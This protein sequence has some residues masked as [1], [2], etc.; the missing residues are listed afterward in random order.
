MNMILYY[1][2]YYYHSKS[3]YPDRV[4]VGVVQQNNDG[5]IDCLYDY[6]NLMKK[7]KG[8]HPET[9]TSDKPEQILK[10]CPHHKQVR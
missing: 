1:Y 2:Y 3:E 8:I 9:T 5:D 7:E 10:N 6:C 4:H